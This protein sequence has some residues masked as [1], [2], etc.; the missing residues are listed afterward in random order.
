MSKMKTFTLEE[1][2]TLL[3]VVKSLLKRSMNGKQTIESIEKERQ[4][5]SH[6]ILLSGGLFVDVPR[7]ARRRA[8][9]D[10]AVQDTK[11]AMGEMEAF[12][13]QIRD[14]VIGLLVF[15]AVVNDRLVLL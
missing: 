11:D 8:E 2:Q 3:P 6:R 10:K 1:A 9:H 5:L 14:R 13:V 12:G 4:D 15:H 7:A